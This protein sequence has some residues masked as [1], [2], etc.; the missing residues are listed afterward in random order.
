MR[1]SALSLF[2]PLVSILL[3]V[4]F[5]YP[6]LEFVQCLESL[7]A[8]FDV[9]KI[10]HTPG[11]STY[12]PIL[13]SSIQNL[14]FNSSTTPKPQI[15]ITPLSESHVQSTIIC[16]KKHGMQTRVRSGG[17]DYE[18]DSYISSTPF[19][20]IDLVNFRKVDVNIKETTAWVQAGAI[21]GEV[22]HSIAKQSKVHAFPAGVCPTIGVGGII[23]GG[24][25]GTIMR[26]FGLAADNV[27]DAVI[28]NA[29]GQILDR[30]SMGE[31]LFWA[32]RGGGGASFGVILSW[33]IK[34]VEV[35]P[36]VT[37]FTVDRTLE[38]GATKLV[39]R[40]QEIADKFHEDLFVRILITSGNNTKGGKTVQAAF[41]SLFLGTT[42]D[43]LPLI[44][45]SFPELG[46]KAS[47]CSEMSWIETI[48]YF[49]SGL[50]KGAPIDALLNR[51][52]A[53][54]FFKAKSDFV[55]T[56][57]PEVGLEGLW[58]LYSQDNTGVII[59]D[60]YGAKMGS[61]SITD[62]P[63]PHR[64]G[65]LY[66]IQYII[67]WSNHTASKVN[68]DWISDV[69]NYMTPYVSKSP[70]SS[71]LNYKDFDLGRN[72][73]SGSY[74]NAISWGTKYFGPNFQRLAKVKA[75][76]DPHNFFRNKDANLVRFTSGFLSSRDKRGWLLNPVNAA[77]DAGISG[78]AVSCA[79]THVGQ[80]RPGGMR[81]NHRHYT[82]NETFVIWGAETK[83]RLENPK[84]AKGYAE[85]LIGAEEVAVVASP[86]GSAHALLNVDPVRTTFFLGCQDSVVTYNTSS[87]DFNVWKDL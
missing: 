78:G 14:R 38:Q 75:T 64:G 48:G 76:V 46:L 50:P 21:L 55:K 49:S 84:V 16:S 8:A 66:N 2:I 52:R 44:Q 39:H 51:A 85:V 17:H 56:P 57:I 80:I 4:S 70:R 68:I 62:T 36:V 54:D 32:I 61:I 10:L 47:D 40:W 5:A 60:P 73:V 81:G 77:H 19:V 13:H 3:S 23:S 41:N 45:K 7:N 6:N 37:V 20:L 25:Q 83:F 31:D 18:G 69:Y 15:I 63:F 1:T 65:T 9:S 34:L 35:P 72:D 30:K 79:S 24:G 26:K 22:Y 86:S 43:L 82:C 87:T 33:K 71:Y 12:L 74:K 42:K 59:L 11:T 29:E 28:V 53:K 67:N 58:K 27:I